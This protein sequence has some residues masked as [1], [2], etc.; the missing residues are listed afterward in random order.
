MDGKAFWRLVVGLLG[1]FI[2]WSIYREHDHNAWIAVA[3]FLGYFEATLREALRDYSRIS[4][5]WPS[6]SEYTT[7]LIPYSRR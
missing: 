7:D 4:C 5:S 1:T 2:A 3:Y 6:R